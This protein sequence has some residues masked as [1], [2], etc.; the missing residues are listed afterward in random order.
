MH[1]STFGTVD[2][3]L[4]VPH[5][6]S[7]YRAPSK[8]FTGGPTWVMWCSQ[9]HLNEE[10]FLYY[11]VY[12]HWPCVRLGQ[13]QKYMVQSWPPSMANFSF[14]N[15]TFFWNPAIL[16]IIHLVG[17][18]KAVYFLYHS[19]VYQNSQ[20]SMSSGMLQTSIYIQLYLYGHRIL[21]IYMYDY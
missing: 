4:D 17:F 15:F 9:H 7:M 21:A 11:H 3:S 19:R 10:S 2:V 18:T 1:L 8:P 14:I 13:R 16:K 12:I 5:I 6:F 20:N